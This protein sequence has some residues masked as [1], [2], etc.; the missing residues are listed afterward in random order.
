M[1][2]DPLMTVQE[3]ADYLHKSKTWVYDHLNTLPHFK[4]GRARLFRKSEIDKWL[5]AYRKGMPLALL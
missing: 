1:M 3:V 5:E 2:D 4:V